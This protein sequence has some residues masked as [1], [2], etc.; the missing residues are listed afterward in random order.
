MRTSYTKY[1]MIV[2]ERTLR[3]NYLSL[4]IF[5]V[6]KYINYVNILGL[7]YSGNSG[8]AA[9]CHTCYLS[10][11]SLFTLCRQGSMEGWHFRL[12]KNY[13]GIKYNMSI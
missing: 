4:P 8:N 2:S 7:P 13:S 3:S 11:I 1:D 5:S 12:A 9:D 6:K 10:E